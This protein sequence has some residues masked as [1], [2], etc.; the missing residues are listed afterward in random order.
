[1]NYELK[2]DSK[3]FYSLTKEIESGYVN[4]LNNG[5]YLVYCGGNQGFNFDK[6]LF[7]AVNNGSFG[8]IISKEHKKYETWDGKERTQ[9]F[10]EVENMD[11]VSTFTRFKKVFNKEVEQFIIEL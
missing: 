10:Y 2:K 3:R 1:M 7:D 6:K 11:G 8:K 4:Q 9:Y 5:N